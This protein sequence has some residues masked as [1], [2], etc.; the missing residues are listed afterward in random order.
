ML[1][2]EHGKPVSLENL[3]LTNLGDHKS[4]VSRLKRAGLNPLEIEIKDDNPL[5]VLRQHLLE[6]GSCIASILDSLG[7]HVVVVD[8]ISKDLS[9][10]RIREPYHGWEIT[11]S[12]KRF[13]KGWRSY[14]IIQIQK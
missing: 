7:G 5:S 9:K 3:I 13:L 12:G 11:I 6:N 10:V 2:M 8:H 1:I 4:M 14:R